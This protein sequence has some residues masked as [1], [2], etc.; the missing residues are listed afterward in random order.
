LTTPKLGNK[1]IV[2]RIL[3]LAG[4]ED[5]VN[6]GKDSKGRVV[7]SDERC[8]YIHGTCDIVSLGKPVS[9]G[10]IHMDPREM[11]DLFNNVPEGSLVYLYLE[12]ENGIEKKE[13]VSKTAV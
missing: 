8:I 2:G 12:L 4:L 11:T 13:K 1:E 5:G 9:S 6:R 7:D 10:C 3:R